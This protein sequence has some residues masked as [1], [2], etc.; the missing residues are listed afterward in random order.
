MVGTQGQPTLAEEW[1]DQE[2]DHYTSARGEMAEDV[3]D[4]IV[5]ESQDTT[6]SQ[7]SVPADQSYSL[8]ATLVSH[9]RDAHGLSPSEYRRE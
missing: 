6:H 7:P 3:R 2:R 5:D 8:D 4:A 1:A 9:I